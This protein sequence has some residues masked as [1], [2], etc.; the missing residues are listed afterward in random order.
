MEVLVLKIAQKDSI[1]ILMDKNFV[2][3]ALLVMLLLIL[4]VVNAIYVLQELTLMIIKTVVIFAQSI[5]F[6]AKGVAIAR[7]ALVEQELPIINNHP[8]QLVAQNL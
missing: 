5:I 8:A 2:R 4:I 7:S 3:H 1:Q 6:P